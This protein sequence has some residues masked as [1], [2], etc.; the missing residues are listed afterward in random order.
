MSGALLRRGENY[1]AE[2]FV[3]AADVYSAPGR[4]GEA[5]WSWYTGSAGWFFRTALFDLAGARFDS[6]RLVLPAE[7]PVR[8]RGG[9]KFT[10]ILP[11]E[12][13]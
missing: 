7:G 11:G 8:D 13:Q 9:Q 6:G 5:G 1:G 4:A 12:A 3:L 10:K 2:P